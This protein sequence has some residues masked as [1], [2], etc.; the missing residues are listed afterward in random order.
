MKGTPGNPSGRRGRPRKWIP[1]AIVTVRAKDQEAA[2]ELAQ[3]LAESIATNP[4]G[5]LRVLVELDG[6]NLEE[7]EAVRIGDI[8]R[9][10]PIVR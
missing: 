10:E 7:A 8:I 2:Q 3:F 9:L 1:N 4:D 6:D 5:S